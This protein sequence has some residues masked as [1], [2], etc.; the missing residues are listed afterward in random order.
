[1]LSRLVGDVVI[2]LEVHVQLKT[3]SK[4]FCS[5]PTNAAEPNTAICPVCLGH[6]G[7]KPVLNSKALE[8][9]AKLALALG[10]SLANSVVF[11]RKT[12]FYPD[13]VK[14]FQITQ[15]EVPLGSNG[16]IVLD[17]GK[18]VRISRVHIEEDPG[19]LVHE[20][21]SVLI[22]Y[23]RSG[24]PLCEIVTAPDMSSPAEAREFMK[25]LLSVLGYLGIFEQDSC[26]IKADA[27]ISIREKNYTRVE[28]KNISGF[29]EIERA[30]AYEVKRQKEQDVKQETRGWDADKGISYSMRSK[31]AEEDYGYIVE[32]DLPL[33]EISSDW[34]RKIQES[35][36]ELA[37]QR[38]ARWAS[39][40]KVD[41]TDAHIIA[42][43]LD[44]AVLFEKVAEFVDP[45]LASHWFRREIL[46]QLNDRKVE[47]KDT[48][49]RSEELIEL[50]QL[51]EK[52][53]ITD[54]IAQQIL[55]QLFDKKFSPKKYVDE[56]KLGRVADES[57]LKKICEDVIAGNA[58]AVEDYRKGEENALMFL[59]GK[60]M[61][62]TKGTAAPNVVKE[63]LKS[64]LK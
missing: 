27:N 41:E 33:F 11:S 59:M 47:L 53:K 3:A 35:I 1:M 12:Y 7:S 4:L 54:R 13:L 36:P 43:D 23:N 42:N 61:R 29:K 14:N 63:L 31:E 6:P 38:A 22:D 24:I 37:S 64:L 62:E 51:L 32:P 17:S 8:F 34:I 15:Y 49:L 57:S 60:V 30:L 45:V 52:K 16:Q 48:Q 21:G 58:K 39:E 20:A 9:G 40:L 55:V 19:A 46:R 10:C 44:V 18:V 2:G 28:L 56:R 26:V 50:F 5:C 25:K